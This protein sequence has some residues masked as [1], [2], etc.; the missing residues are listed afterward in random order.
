MRMN[1]SSGRHFFW[2]RSGAVLVWLVLGSVS[3]SGQSASVAGL[4]ED[5]KRIERQ[6][7]QLRLAVEQLQAENRALRGSLEEL[8]RNQNEVNAAI[9]RLLAEGP[10][11]PRLRE[12]WEAADEELKQ[13][14]V[15][16][17]GRQMKTL[18]E[19]VDATLANQGRPSPPRTGGGGEPVRFEDD[20]PRTGIEYTVQ[21]GDTLSGLAQKF[22]SSVRDIQNANRIA[23]PA[24]LQVGRVIFI[25]QAE[26]EGN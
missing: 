3:A 12:Q 11:S 19:R 26:T 22:G 14:L 24:R 18:A 17:V 1:R 9:N 7:G 10:S 16:E 4:A 21:G 20:F 2:I 8:R 23:D 15:E 6:V 25:P 5:V 13:A